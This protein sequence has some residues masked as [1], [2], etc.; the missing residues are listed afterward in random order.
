MNP[1][2][3][4]YSA[5]NRLPKASNT[6]NSHSIFRDC[7]QVKENCA[8]LLVLSTLVFSKLCFTQHLE[9]SIYLSPGIKLQQ[10]ASLPTLS[11]QAVA[12]DG[13]VAAGAHC[14]LWD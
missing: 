11:G 5:L 1:H 4:F 3:S 13:S 2:G 14:T 10:I 6:C 9:S 12:I 7:E 8:T